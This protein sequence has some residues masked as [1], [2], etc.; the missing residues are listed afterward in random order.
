MRKKYLICLVIVLSII[1]FDQ[2]SKA[3][4]CATMQFY[5]SRM[6][7]ENLVNIT[8]IM[9]AGA[10]FGFLAQEPPLF[11][12]LFFALATVAAVGLII[13]HLLKSRDDEPLLVWA[14]SLIL[15]GAL[16]NLIDRVRFGA[17]VDFIDVYWKT[18]HWPAFN[19]A[20][21]AISLGAMLMI[22]EL[23]QRGKVQ[24]GEV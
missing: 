8:Y 19:V 11:R 13:F 2:L 23:L 6:I 12:S 21:S 1:L 17:V 4:I 5:D 15:G 22:W 7:I 14:L 18:Y 9:N 20:D 24:S 16:G 10:A 3:Y